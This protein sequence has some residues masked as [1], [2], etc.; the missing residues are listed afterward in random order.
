MFDDSSRFL[1]K[2]SPDAKFALI[3]YLGNRVRNVRFFSYGS[4]MNKNKF[5]EDMKQAAKKLKLP[6][7]DES[8]LCLDPSTIKRELLHFRRELSNESLRGRAFSIYPSMNDKV[9]GIC[10][11]IDFS[12]L[13]A[14]LR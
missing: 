12:V 13:P 4:N 9:E 2:L 7:K 1:R 5:K 14:F 10:H 6:L 11:N 3:D 8:K